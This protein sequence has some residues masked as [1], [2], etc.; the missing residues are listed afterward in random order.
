MIRYSLKCASDH[1]FESWFQN[2]AAFDGLMQ[3]RLITCPECGVN[4]VEKAIMA[5]RIR[6][7]RNAVEKADKPNLATPEGKQENDLAK[8]RK[9]IE[10]DSE[11]VGVQFAQEA[12]AMHEGDAP[13]RAIYGEAK[14]EEAVKLIEDGVKIAPLPFIPSRK[15]N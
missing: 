8:L 13:E 12:R 5:P 11:Y 4:K 1:S 9:S 14:P 15:T 2:A 3:K 10:A 6:P 7:A